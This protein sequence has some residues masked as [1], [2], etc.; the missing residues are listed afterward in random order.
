MR[1]PQIFFFSSLLSSSISLWLF[2]W[3][4]SGAL[5]LNELIHL[6]F[7]NHSIYLNNSLMLIWKHS[8]K[9]HKKKREREKK[10]AHNYD[11]MC[12][13]NAVKCCKIRKNKK[14]VVHSFLSC[15]FAMATH[16]GH[17]CH[18]TTIAIWKGQTRNKWEKEKERERERNKK[19]TKSASN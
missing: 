5:L 4:L 18:S 8:K 13:V 2:N 7:Q 1:F 15:S 6:K 10:C 16:T 11:G 19:T 14:G 9:G 17:L 3:L 12:D